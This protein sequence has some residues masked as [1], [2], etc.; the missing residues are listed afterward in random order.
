M[1]VFAA[2]AAPT[3]TAGGHGL[4]TGKAAAATTQDWPTY[5]H[6]A[7]RT[8]ASGDATLTPAN[9]QF[10]QK[11][12]AAVTGGVIAAEPAIVNGIAY[13]GS[14]DG[15]EYAINANTGTVIWKTFLGTITD[16]PCAPPN[17]GIIFLGHDLQRR[18]LRR[19]RQ[20]RA[21]RGAVVRIVGQRPARSSGTF[22]PASDPVAGPYYNWSSPLIITDPADGLPYAYIG[23]A[24]VCDAPLVPGQLLKVSLTTHQVVGITPMV[25]TG[26]VGGGIWTSPTYDPDDQ[27]DLRLHRDPQPLLADA[28]PGDRGDQRHDHD[29]RRSLA[30][31][32]SRRR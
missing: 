22:P 26:Q 31:C 19:W 4:V 8:S 17:A 24:S 9:V 27:Q 21:Q 16:P 25:P 15:Y 32:P 13:V 3:T 2:H 7:A 1:A 5:L 30:A 14:W 28:L 23:T 10:L 6:D 12:F 11:K 20:R 18:R 29:G